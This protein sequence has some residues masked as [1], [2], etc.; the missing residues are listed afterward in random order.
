MPRTK[1]L[2]FGCLLVA[3][4]LSFS[5]AQADKVSLMSLPGVQPKF[6]DLD[7][8]LKRRVI[9]V[10]VP[11][12][13]TMFFLDKG[14]AYGITIEF[15]REFEKVLN[16]KY[17]KKPFYIEVAVIPTHSD[18]LLEE[19][20]AGR[21]DIA[22]GNLTVTPERSAIVDFADPIGEGA[23]EVVVTGPTAPAIAS[24]D[25]LGGKKLVVRK[26]S[27]YYQHL[28]ALNERLKKEGKPVINLVPADPA[29]ED[30][31]IL[32]MV[33][34]GLM[35]L[36]VVDLHIA[37]LWAKI[38]KNLTVHDDLAVN[39]GGKIAWAL[40]KNTPKLMAE[41]NAFMATH[42]MG[43][44]FGNGLIS[45]YL[46]DGRIVKNALAPERKKVLNDLIPYFKE[47]GDQSQID[48]FILA[49]QGF[50]ESSFDQKLRMKSGAVGVMQM[51]PSTA[52]EELGIL[53]I[54]THAK[55]NIH[56]AA[57][58]LRFIIK[59]Y[60]SDP[61]ISDRDRVL[62]ALAA[63]NGG[64]SALTRAR[65]D[66][67]KKGFDPNVWFDNVEYDSAAVSGQEPVQYVG[68]IYKYFLSYK[69]LLSGTEAES[70]DPSAE[71]KPA[72]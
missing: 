54:V 33:G 14:E 28:L 23:K 36:T 19:L 3:C 27:S 64:P 15:L 51:K 12:S 6:Y 42:R 47:Y 45:Q 8:M 69:E 11:P 71:A 29:L 49:A 1:L 61:G 48:P 24:L 22:A 53:D 2:E 56:S 31:D 39:E 43:T 21:G 26:S 18:K 60:I 32:E 62:M 63:Y 34:S 50:Q 16:K 57:A 9:R 20:K 25:D 37:K 40:R 67:K 68:H 17:A 38:Y 4:C 44:E 7:T 66:A 55:D 59:K 46:N 58:Y 13:R 35:P 52:K 41:V 72:K 5:G 65:S 70:K 10:L 30:E